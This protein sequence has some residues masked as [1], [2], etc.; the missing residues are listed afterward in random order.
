M[1][2]HS[3]FQCLAGIS[4][5]AIIACCYQIYNGY[6]LLGMSIL[7]FF[8]ST[9]SK[10]FTESH[11]SDRLKLTVFAGLSDLR[12]G[13]VMSVTLRVLQATHTRVH[14]RLHSPGIS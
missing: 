4:A 1:A 13:S 12:L 14:W 8:H 6:L 7:R 9:G 2:W 5:A 10:D 3:V 11:H